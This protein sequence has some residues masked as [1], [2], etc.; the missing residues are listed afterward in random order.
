MAFYQIDA[1]EEDVIVQWGTHVS[2]KY[3]DRDVSKRV[4]KAADPFI[5]VRGDSL[6]IPTV[7]DV[8]CS[9]VAC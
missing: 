7:A 4:R 6:L 3:V 2:R 1:L 8:H 9:I 5:K